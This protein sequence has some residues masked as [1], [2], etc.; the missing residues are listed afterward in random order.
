MIVYIRSR[1]C[2][3]LDNYVGNNNLYFIGQNYH[4]REYKQDDRVLR[5]SEGKEDNVNTIR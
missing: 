3:I 1:F 5:F 2:F 4:R